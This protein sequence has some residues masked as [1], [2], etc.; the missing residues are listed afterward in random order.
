MNGD[1]TLIHASGDGD[2]GTAA[3]ACRAFAVTP[4]AFSEFSSSMRGLR[5]CCCGHCSDGGCVEHGTSTGTSWGVWVLTA[6]MDG[7]EL[8]VM[9]VFDGGFCA[10]PRAFSVMVDG[11]VGERRW[12]LWQQGR[13]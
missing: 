11:M 2:L 12:W 3:L 9:A 5:C 4:A 13:V 7:V 1:T 6:S 8:I 10:G